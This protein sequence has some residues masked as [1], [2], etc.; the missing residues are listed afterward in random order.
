MRYLGVQNV[1]FAHLIALRSLKINLLVLGG[2]VLLNLM[3]LDPFW[4]KL[5]HFTL[6]ILY[7]FKLSLIEKLNQFVYFRSFHNAKTNISEIDCK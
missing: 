5:R 3:K 1:Q 7:F 6:N 4:G 2:F